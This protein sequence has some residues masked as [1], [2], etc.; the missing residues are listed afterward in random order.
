MS[1]TSPH[2]RPPLHA[3]ARSAALFLRVADS[4]ERSAQLAEYHAKRAGLKGCDGSA[5]QELAQ[6]RRARQDA[7]RARALAAERR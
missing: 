3:R 4:L 1:S 5:E 7:A 6:A 2:Q